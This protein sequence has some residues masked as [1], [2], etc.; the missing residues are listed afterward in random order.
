MAIR[1]LTKEELFDPEF[2]ASVQRLRILARRVARG[3]RP[4]EQRS[5]DLGSGIEFQDFRPYSY[6]DDFRAIDWNIYRRLGKVFIRLFEEM[7][8]L[9]VYVAP[10]ISNSLFVEDSP[11]VLTTLRASLAL[12]AIALN[13]HDSVGLFP[14]SDDLR[15]DLRPASGRGRLTRL[16]SALADLQ[17]NGQTDF[18]K[19]FNT[20][21]HRKLRSGLLVIVSDFFDPNGIEAVLDALRP[22]RHRLLLLQVTRPEDRT[23]TLGGDLELLDCETGEVTE[24]SVTAATRARYTQAYDQFQEGLATVAKSRGCGLLRIDASRSLI[25]QLAHLCEGG[26]VVP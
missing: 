26:S 3:G 11:R 9:P 12:G 21:S 19:A 5:K 1:T 7:E 15:M 14:F 22:L 20:L 4:A 10:D 23:P 25:P 18:R 24:V 17:P 13:Q 16:A 8:D 2:M 6:G